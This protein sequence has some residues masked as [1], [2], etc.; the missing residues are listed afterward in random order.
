ML[1]RLATNS[2]VEA[3]KTL[4][5][6]VLAEFGLKPDSSST[7]RDIDNIEKHYTHR[8]GLFYVI[9]DN[10]Q[11]IATMG[12]YQLEASICELRKMY[13]LPDYRG[14]GIGKRLLELAI[15]K[16][17]Q[18]GYQRMELETA[19]P[20]KTAVA[21]YQSYGFKEFNPKHLASRCDRAFYLDL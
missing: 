6:Q 21:L 19:S 7:D 10:Q 9:E 13:L 20:L 3:I 12:V 11:V 1:L 8:N 4:V 16:A 18:L 15:D 5:F 17:K 14:T 2:D